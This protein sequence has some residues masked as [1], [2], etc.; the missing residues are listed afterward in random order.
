[1]L[2]FV[3]TVTK[4]WKNVKYTKSMVYIFIQPQKFVKRINITPQIFHSNF[5]Q[6]VNKYQFLNAITPIKRN[7]KNSRGSYGILTYFVLSLNILKWLGF[8]DEDEKKESELIM[9]L[10]RAVLSTQR[11]EYNKAE[12]LLHLALRLAQQQQ[13]Q[14]GITYCYDLMANLA[15]ETLQLDKSE[16]LFVSV[17]QRLLSTGVKDN[18]LKVIHISLKLARIL[19]LKAEVEKAELG[20]EWCLEQIKDQKNDSIDGKMLCGIIHDWY[21]QFL[22]D[23]G[24]LEKS[25]QHLKEA[26]K[27][28]AEIEGN[29]TEANMLLLNDLG[30][31]CWR[32]G[33]LSM[34]EKFLNEAIGVGSNLEDKMHVGTVHANLGLIYLQKGITKQAN[35]YCKEAW[36]IGR[37]YEDNEAVE[38]ANYCFDQIKVVLDHEKSQT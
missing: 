10:K 6:Y 26:Y 16:K 21:A 25:L 13:D 19:H 17:L 12:Q 29:N 32:A 31:T 2:N 11:Q 8:E 9:T 7:T 22:L 1:M 38:Q 37:K 36:H 5:L 23:G 20:Y 35:K 18:D 33:D 15:F 34:A 30:I 14:Q 28:C 24:Q 27:I 4:L 3:N